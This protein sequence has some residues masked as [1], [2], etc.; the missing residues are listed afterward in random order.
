MEFILRDDNVVGYDNIVHI[1]IFRGI[2][3]RGRGEQVPKEVSNYTRR[4]SRS[5]YVMYF[6]TC[7]NGMDIKRRCS[8]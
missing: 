5:I 4:R 1:R 2:H 3:V 7:R 6:G 8:E